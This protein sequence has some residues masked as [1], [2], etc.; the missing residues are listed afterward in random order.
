MKTKRIDRAN[1]TDVADRAQQAYRAQHT[2][3]STNPNFLWGQLVCSNS[4]LR[5]QT[6][7]HEIKFQPIPHE[8]DPNP[9]KS[10][11]SILRPDLMHELNAEEK[12]SDSL[13]FQSLE[14]ARARGKRSKLGKLL[15]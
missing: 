8:T 3:Y 5:G 11:T 13:K 4:G 2:K 14:R 6:F 15:R 1:K 9:E 7:F 10:I 12:E